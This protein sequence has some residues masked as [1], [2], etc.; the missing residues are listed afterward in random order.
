MLKEKTEKCVITRMRQYNF[1]NC[2]ETI[3]MA[4]SQTGVQKKRGKGKG[5]NTE[6]KD[7]ERDTHSDS[8]GRKKKEDCE[9]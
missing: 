7:V 2:S 3:V 6:E 4:H 1:P 5:E 9:E 8:D